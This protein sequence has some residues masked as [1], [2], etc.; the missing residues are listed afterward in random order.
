M[1]LKDIGIAFKAE[2]NEAS[3]GTSGLSANV[4]TAEVC[5]HNFCALFVYKLLLYEDRT[6][7]IFLRKKEGSVDLKTVWSGV[8]VGVGRV[9]VIHYEMLIDNHILLNMIIL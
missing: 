9:H 5:L 3:D 6:C 8:G 4:Q 1:D 2:N 7:I